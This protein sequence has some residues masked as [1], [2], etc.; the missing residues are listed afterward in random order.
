M[1]KHTDKSDKQLGA[2]VNEHLLKLGIETPFKINHSDAGPITDDAKLDALITANK[3][4]HNI[5]GMD[6]TDDSIA[7]TPKRI[8]KLQLFE[9]MKGLDYKNFPKMTVVENKFYNGIVSVNDILVMSLCEHHWERV[10]MRVSIGYIPKAGG[11]V[12]GLS[13]LSRLADFFG[14]RPIVQERF[15]AQVYE[16]LKL[17]METDDVAVHVRGIHLCMFAR[18][19]KEPCSNTTTTL[20]GGSFEKEGALRNEFLSGIDISKPIIP[21]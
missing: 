20:L 13:K 7:E 2:L 14:S 8:A 18:G 5:L 1:N 12:V 11:K 16:A 10:I 19:V 15:T 3:Q 4:M 17:I 9:S 6:L 21:V